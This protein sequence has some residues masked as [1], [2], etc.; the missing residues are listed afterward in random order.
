MDRI[1][2]EFLKTYDSVGRPIIR[3]LKNDRH[4]NNKRSVA[5]FQNLGGDKIRPLWLR[6]MRDKTFSPHTV[7]VRQQPG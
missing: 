6:V 2:T 5:D 4:V 7:L 1:P 3:R